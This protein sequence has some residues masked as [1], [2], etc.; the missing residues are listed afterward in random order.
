MSEKNKNLFLFFPS[1]AY[2]HGL[3]DVKIVQMSEKNKNLFLFF[4]ECSLSSWP[5]GHKDS[6]SRARIQLYLRFS[7]AQLFILPQNQLGEFWF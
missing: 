7:E 3:W 5:L 6:A 2:L 4:S 1:A